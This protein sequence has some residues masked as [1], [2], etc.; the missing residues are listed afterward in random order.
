ML[1]SVFPSDELDDYL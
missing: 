1:P